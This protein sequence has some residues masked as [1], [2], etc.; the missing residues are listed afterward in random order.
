[1]LTAV[2]GIAT[3]IIDG[4]KDWFTEIIGK[5]GDI[6]DTIVGLPKKIVDL[7][8]DL[9]QFLFIP[10]DGFLD[11]KITTTKEKL[12]Q[13]FNMET[14]EQLMNALKSYVSGK[15][16]FN[17]Y[18]DISMWTEHLPTVKDFIRGFFYPLIIIA[19][20]KWI[21]WLLRGTSPIGDNGSSS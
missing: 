2:K 1:M 3:S 13:K 9:F 15:L 7:L 8:S 11:T 4:F 6:F 12:A 19:D 14:Y 5:I 16:N 10:K 18:I 21:I 17:G 20:V